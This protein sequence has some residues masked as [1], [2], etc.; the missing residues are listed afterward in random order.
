MKNE[1]LT[2][3][4]NCE[5]VLENFDFEKGGRKIQHTREEMIDYVSNIFPT[6][7]RKTIIGVRK[8]RF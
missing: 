2:T 7:K 3:F 4:E 5:R 8:V 1:T 6:A